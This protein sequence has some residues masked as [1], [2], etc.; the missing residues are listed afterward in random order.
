MTAK[1]SLLLFCAAVGMGGAAAAPLPLLDGGGAVRPLPRPAII[2]F[3][4]SWCA[5]CQAELRGLATLQKAVAP[6]PVILVAL[7][8][9]VRSRAM[10][11]HVDPEAVRYPGSVDANMLNLVPGGA[12]GVPFAIAFDRQG[13]A[14]GQKGGGV[15]AADIVAWRDRCLR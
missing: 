9:S 8:G 15:A 3:W 14:C 1:I 6:M 12:P 11:R 2:L 13:I 4:A 10:L 7:D 5:P